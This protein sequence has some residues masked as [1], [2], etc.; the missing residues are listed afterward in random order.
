M[1]IDTVFQPKLPTVLVVGAGVQVVPSSYSGQGSLMSY[2]VV[3]L[4]STLQRF[5]Y[6]PTAAK[7]LA[8]AVTPTGTGISAITMLPS[9]VAVFEFSTGVFVAADNA[10]GFEFTPGQGA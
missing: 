9:S 2:R 5:G 6:G 7:A 8:A 1:S 4:S 3:N 10:T